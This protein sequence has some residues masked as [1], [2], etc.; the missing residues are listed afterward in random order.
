[1]GGVVTDIYDVF[2]QNKEQRTASN[3]KAE[4]LR[5]ARE[6]MDMQGKQYEQNRADM[7]PWREQGKGALMSMSDLMGTSGNTGAAG[8]GSLASRFK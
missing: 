6:A 3:Q 8:Y 7:A 1:M 5:M 4:M 2:G